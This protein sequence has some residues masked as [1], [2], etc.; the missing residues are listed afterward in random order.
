MN[1]C[2]GSAKN[3]SIIGLEKCGLGYWLV[4]AGFIV[5][6]VIF[7]VIAVKLSIRDQNLK[8]KYG[9]INVAE[10]DIRYSNGKRLTVLLVLG[11]A[12]GLVAGALGLGGGSAY[13]PALL[14]MG[15]PPRVASATGLYLV[16]F[17]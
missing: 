17:S 8:L 6:C 5:A 9:G 12:G 14:A 2:M 1:L 4:Q 7:A 3:P 11:F 15:I 13:N 16:T 10:S